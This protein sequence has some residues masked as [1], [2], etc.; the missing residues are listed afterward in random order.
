M[1]ASVKHKITSVNFEN[2]FLLIITD[3]KTYK[4]KLAELSEKLL[5]ATEEERS[6]YK[7]SPSGYGIHWPML[8]EDISLQGIVNSGYRA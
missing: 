5:K 6:F 3:E 7:I 4:L 8:D 2:D 1:R